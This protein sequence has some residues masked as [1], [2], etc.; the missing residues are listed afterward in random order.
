MSECTHNCSTCSNGD[1]KDRTSMIEQPHKTTKIG[2]IIGV[3]SGKGGVGKS[4]ITS[5]VAVNAN[6]SGLKTA[7]M[8]ADILGPSIPKSFGFTENDRA[9][10]SEEGLIPV[11]T[12]SNIKVMSINLLLEESTKPVVWRGPVISAVV[13]QFYTDVLWG[14][15][16][17]MFIDMPPGTGDVPLTVFQ[18]LPLDGII[19]VTTP[20]DLVKMVVEKSVNMARMMNVPVL[21]IVENMSY[22][23]CPDCGKKQYIFGKGIGKKISD[24]YGLKLLAEVPIDPQVTEKINAGRVEDIDVSCLNDALAVIKDFKK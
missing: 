20:Q 10:G 24:E 11:T 19:I 5:M 22:Y 15:N 13:K 18:S 7:I 21:G 17:V 9:V 1:C 23:V 14:E 6:K 12:P 3:V 8:D 16:D 4:F 2:K